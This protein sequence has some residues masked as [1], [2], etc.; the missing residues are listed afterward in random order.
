VFTQN[1]KESK[2]S[3]VGKKIIPINK[4]RSRGHYRDQVRLIHKGERVY[5]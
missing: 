5:T 1:M 2:Y 3:E 4:R